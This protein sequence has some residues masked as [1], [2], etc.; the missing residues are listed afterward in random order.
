MPGQRGVSRRSAPCRRTYRARIKQN[1][2]IY[3][4]RFKRLNFFPTDPMPS[5]LTWELEVLD[6]LE[7]RT[8]TELQTLG[9]PQEDWQYYM[10]FQKRLWEA[11]VKFAQ[12]TFQLEKQ[13]LVN[14][15]VLRGWN[16]NALQALQVIAENLAVT[17]VTK[18]WEK[19][20]TGEFTPQL[21][22]TATSYPV[23]SCMQRK[24]I[25]AAGRFWAFY[26]PFAGELGF[27]SKQP[28]GSWSAYTS[29]GVIWPNYLGS[30]AHQMDVEVVGDQVFIVIADFYV[31]TGYDRLF[32]RRGTL[33]QDGTITWASAWQSIETTDAD[34]G[35]VSIALDT[36]NDYIFVSSYWNRFPNYYVRVWRST[37]LNGGPWTLVR[38]D[39][40]FSTTGD[41]TKLLVTDGSDLTFMWGAATQGT[42]RLRI[43]GDQG[44]SWSTNY[45]TPATENI[46]NMASCALL[47]IYPPEDAIH[48]VYNERDDQ[49]IRHLVFDM[50]TLSWGAP[51]DVKQYASIN[52]YATA[53]KYGAGFQVIYCERGSNHLARRKWLAGVWSA[54]DQPFG[55]TF[56]APWYPSVYREAL[57]YLNYKMGVLWMEKTASPYDLMS[58]WYQDP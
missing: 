52:I 44:S 10:G 31:V 22:S 23:Y 5:E 50:D 16:L 28:Y 57:D 13:S 11:R 41:Q 53:F 14:E 17:K 12:A 36:V 7:Q 26:C 46:Y 18:I 30:Q 45:D 27:R 40:A 3:V 9:V 33:N 55:T 58:A 47:F 49:K 56:N 37:D 2:A 21:V 34:K 29:L 4:R 32:F 20:E 6:A 43:S 51:E 39:N 48:L 54:E 25:Y 8:Y 42:L 19:V 35:L 38:T 1:R 15:Y 24:I